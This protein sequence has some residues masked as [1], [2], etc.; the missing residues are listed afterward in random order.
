[1]RKKMKKIFYQFRSLLVANKFRGI[2]FSCYVFIAEIKL[3]ELSDI[4]RFKTKIS[5]S[6]SKIM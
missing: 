2:A 4:T 3:K 5:S 6:N 1:M